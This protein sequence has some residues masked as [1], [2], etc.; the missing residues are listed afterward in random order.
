LR[1][2]VTSGEAFEPYA[3]VAMKHLLGGAV[4]DVDEDEDVLEAV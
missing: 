4:W 1:S 3:A 2:K